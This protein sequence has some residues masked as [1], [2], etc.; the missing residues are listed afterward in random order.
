MPI[1]ERQVP[2]IPKPPLVPPSQANTNPSP[3]EGLTPPAPPPL[4]P[5]TLNIGKSLKAADAQRTGDILWN[6]Q[7]NIQEVAENDVLELFTLEEIGEL[8]RIQSRLRIILQR[9]Q[10]G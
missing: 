6:A 2:N 5:V 3:P 9:L 4:S 7:Y 1:K 8:T 10:K